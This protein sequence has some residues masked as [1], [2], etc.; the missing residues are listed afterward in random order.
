MGIQQFLPGLCFVA[1]KGALFL[2][3]TFVIV[4]I[5]ICETVSKPLG[6]MEYRVSIIAE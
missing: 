6:E 2:T 3:L 4:F 5:H 1:T